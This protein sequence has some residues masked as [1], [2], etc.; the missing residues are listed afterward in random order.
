MHTYRKK[1]SSS[2]KAISSHPDGAH[3]SS[4]LCCLFVLIVMPTLVMSAD[5]R[6]LEEVVV[7]A[8][9]RGTTALQD[10]PEA[11]QAIDGKTLK[12][13]GAQTFIDFALSVP[14]LQYQDLGPGDKE[15]VIR[16]INSS[17]P[18]T[19]G[20]YYDEAVITGSNKEDGGGRNA[21][22]K[23]YD[24]ERIEVLKGPQGTL[25]GANSMAGTIR[26]VTNKPNLEKFEGY[27]DG[28]FSSTNNGGENYDVNAM[29]NF[30]IVEGLLGV[31]VVGWVNDESG[32][33][34]AVR[35]PS[36][37]RENINTDNTEGGRITFRLT[38]SEN[39]VLTA[40]ATVQNLK[41]NGSSR[42]TPE[43]QNSF[44]LSTLGFPSVPGGDLI[45]TDIAQSPW[46]EDL[47]VYGLVGEYNTTF[48]VL[49]ATTNYF[50]RD[51][52]FLF[53]TSPFLAA[54]PGFQDVF[55]FPFTSRE[56][57]DR[58]V[59][60]SE[61]RFA[62]DLKGPL[63]FVVGGFYQEDDIDFTVETLRINDFGLPR[64]PFSS[65]DSD[66]AV[67]NFP[68]GNTLFGRINNSSTEQLA[69]F[70]E[71]TFDITDKLTALAGVRYF[72]STLKAE[73]FVTHP[74]FGFGGP[75]DFVVSH[76]RDTGNKTTVK[77]NLAYTLTDDILV[78]ATASQGFRVGG[79]NPADLPFAG[80]EIPRGF[81]PDELWNYELGVKSEFMDGKAR[82]NLAGYHIDWK[83][84]QLESRTSDGIFPFISNF[85]KAEVDGLEFETQFLPTD[86][87][88]LSINGSYQRAK[89]T[90]DTPDT[91]NP[92]TRGLS[93][94]RIPNIPRF[95]G[96]FTADYSVPISGLF[97]G[98]LRTD[99]S[100][101][102]KAKTEF[103]S[104][105]PFNVNLNDFI[106]VNLRASLESDQWTVTVFAD[107]VTDKRAQLD[108]INSEQDGIALLT[109]RPRTIGV[110]VNRKF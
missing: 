45:N 5:S 90:E 99:L 33:I 34:D 38:P 83:D 105:H 55:P 16:G 12:A 82:V 97:T 106:L 9:K 32:F 42:F 88:E 77:F 3:H 79:L 104:A 80:G 101:R 57:R 30:P 20:V 44:D 107:N 76:T 35:I 72:D 59:W 10:T 66:D 4:A 108:A 1:V 48:G 40:S 41:S 61:I 21:D 74:F 75:P 64:G 91:G 6:I 7:T 51:I 52:T 8:T 67:T 15:Y 62:S 68:D 27:V 85:G 43:G 102:G 53:D 95:Q 65:L 96:H 54:N 94:D 26:F 103:S 47:Q 92:A 84:L 50:K 63:Q 81:G 49:T 78:Y 58:T 110:S 17:G 31:R 56:P 25:Y 36:G 22:I 39:L 86:Q 37:R 73:E 28:T 23:L 24:L 14:S 18:S 13:M 11:I 100:Y 29:L 98:H 60:S 69:F 89:L 87:L 2:V 46:D 70:G 19:V 93:G 109:N 71:V